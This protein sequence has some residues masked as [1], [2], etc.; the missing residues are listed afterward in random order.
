MATLNTIGNNKQSKR[1]VAG[2]FSYREANAFHRVELI[3]R[4]RRRSMDIIRNL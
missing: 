1:R 3:E 2:D 4:Y